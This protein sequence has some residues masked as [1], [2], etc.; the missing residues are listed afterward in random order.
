[1]PHFFSAALRKVSTK[2]FATTAIALGILTS[3]STFAAG[4]TGGHRTWSSA[5]NAYQSCTAAWSGK[6]CFKPAGSSSVTS[7]WNYTATYRTQAMA[8][9]T[10]RMTLAYHDA[11]TILPNYAY[12][13]E[14]KVNGKAAKEFSL[15]SKQ[16]MQTASVEP[17]ELKRGTNVIELSWV[18][19]QYA[20]PVDTNLALDAVSAS[21]LKAPALPLVTL[22][23]APHPKPKPRPKPHKPT[24]AERRQQLAQEMLRNPHIAYWNTSHGST[25]AIV[26]DLAAGRCAPVA[27]PNAHGCVKELDPRVLETILEISKHMNVQVNALTDKWH[28]NGSNHYKGKAADLSV[29]GKS[30][31]QQG[32]MAG[33][34]RR[35]GGFRNSETSHIHLNYY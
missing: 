24:K 11:G 9:G 2:L 26:V 19:D 15:P 8:P 6:Y 28:T 17:F 33:I 29:I 20:P 35:H 4:T 10:Y 16:G 18:N 7:F 12:R 34:A 23:S 22:G 21:F 27:A 14:V 32:E 25:R 30:Y 3:V 31:A 1:M 5:G 13:I